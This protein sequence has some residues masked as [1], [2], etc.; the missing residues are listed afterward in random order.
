M[1]IYYLDSSLNYG[2]Q[3]IK[4][5]SEAA[6]L[7]ARGHSITIVGRPK[8]KIVQHAKEMELKCRWLEMPNS[9][10]P[11]AIW[12]LLR[13]IREDQV[14]ILHSHSAKDAWIS[15]I[16]ARLSGKRPTIFRTR[17]ITTPIKHRIAYSWLPDY[18]V[19]IS[20]AMRNS[21]TFEHGIDPAKIVLITP[22]VD[23][24]RFD[25][26]P[27]RS[28][29]RGELGFSQEEFLIGMVAEFRGEKDHPTLLRAFRRV[30]DQVGH[31]KLLLAGEE[32]R[33]GAKIR[34]LVIQLKLQN[35]VQFLGFR[36][37]VPRIMRALD[38]SVLSSTREPFGQV[39]LEAMAAG[40]P[41]IA[42]RVE[43]PLE[44]IQHGDTGLLFEPGSDEALT[45]A[46]LGIHDNKKRAMQLAH[47]AL[48]RVRKEYDF[49][50]SIERLEAIYQEK[51][52]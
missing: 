46:L 43:G 16:A 49:E 21:F 48:I 18:L 34:D 44:V 45:K 6:A 24:R 36:K 32:G 29:I 14:S 38:V 10:S 23:L 9:L 42:T 19:V 13:W 27:S 15:G 33:K 1:V 40:T 52:R 50:R 22:C 20:C 3:E 17:H 30:L 26:L 28:T 2:G 47:N 11:L 5:L 37:D 4:T 39:L 41:V 7:T 35:S 12:T 8:S 25:C 51:A 31:A